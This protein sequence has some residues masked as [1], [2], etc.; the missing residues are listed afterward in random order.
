MNYCE[1]KDIQR[2]MKQFTISTTSKP[3]VEDVNRFIVLISEGEIEPRLREVISLP[4]TDEIGLKLLRSIAVKGVISKVYEALQ[5]DIDRIKH[6]RDSFEKGLQVAI[7]R[8]SM[9]L[10]SVS[11]I[12]PGCTSSYDSTRDIRYPRDERQW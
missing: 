9:L 2:E 3:T 6:Y 4:V 8:P 10:G 11:S 7:D 5:A 1:V 12:A